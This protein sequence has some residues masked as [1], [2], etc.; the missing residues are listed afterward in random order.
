MSKDA[1]G[2]ENKKQPALEDD[3]PCPVAGKHTGKPMIE[4]PASYL[5]WLFKQPWC[6]GKYLTTYN[7]IYNSMQALKEEGNL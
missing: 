4:V 5:L 6:E 1:Y 2:R 7:Y 3:S